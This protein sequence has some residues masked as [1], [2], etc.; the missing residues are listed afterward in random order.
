MNP[1]IYVDDSAESRT[2]LAEP[3]IGRALTWSITQ[4]RGE[5]MQRRQV[6]PE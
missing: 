5:A 1:T 3:V 4:L 6:F 2:G